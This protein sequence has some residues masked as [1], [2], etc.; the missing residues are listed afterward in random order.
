[1]ARFAIKGAYVHLRAIQRL[2]KHVPPQAHGAVEYASPL[3][4]PVVMEQIMWR[5]RAF[6]WELVGAFDMFLQ[7]ANDHFVL[8]LAGDK[9]MWAA[10][11]TSSS[12]DQAGW[13]AMRKLLE[14]GYNSEWYYEVRMYRNF[15]HRSILP[16]KSIIPKIPGE[17]QVFLPHARKG[18][19]HYD[20]IRTQLNSY[21]EQMLAL[22]RRLF[23]HQMSA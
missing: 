2:L 6:F 8:G 14:D 5:T 1:M 3:S 16:M 9:V 18:Q 4:D 22:G 13:T 15:A 19:S 23:E 20:D 10:M 21:I 12:R 11:P 17:T 7:W